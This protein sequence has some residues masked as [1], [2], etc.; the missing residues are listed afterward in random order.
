MTALPDHEIVTLVS[1]GKLISENF[2][3]GSVTPNGYDLRIGSMK[4]MSDGM[5]SGEINI[6]PG[7]GLW[8]STLEYLRIPADIMGQIWLRS[9]YTRK[10]LMGSF[11]AVESGFHGSLTLSIFN[12]GPHP[13]AIRTGDRIAQIVFHMLSSEPELGYVDRSGNYAG[14]RGINTGNVVD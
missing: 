2:S 3:P 8:V 12:L 7:S 13:V 5:E 11:G 4:L 6:S 10:G 1:S 9:S 14:S